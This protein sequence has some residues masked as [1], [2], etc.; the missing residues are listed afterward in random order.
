MV[1]APTLG[2]FLDSPALSEAAADLAARLRKERVVRAGDGGLRA[3]PDAVAESLRLAISNGWYVPCATRSVT[4]PKSSG[5]TRRLTMLAARDHVVHSALAR[6]MGR[7]LDARFSDRS[8]AFRPGRGHDQAARRVARLI[9]GGARWAAD[10]DVR[11]CFGT[12]DIALLV[13]QMRAMGIVDSALHGLLEAVLRPGLV[14]FAPPCGLAQGSPLSP[15]LANVHLH[16]IDEAL[17]GLLPYQR[18]A[19]DLVCVCL[20]RFDAEAA[21]A[22]MLAAVE[23]RWLEASPRKSGVEAIAPGWRCLG[24]TVHAEGALR[25]PDRRHG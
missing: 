23:A 9:R 24:W 5:G 3:D 18:Y 21:Y 11:D 8:F 4:I 1:A 15:L 12:V 6:H 14:R 17:A 25:P 10:L 2:S 7:Y 13:A 19:D 16:P 20:T 22:R